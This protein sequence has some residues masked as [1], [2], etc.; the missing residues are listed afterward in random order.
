VGV[1]GIDQSV[2]RRIED[3]YAL[4]ISSADILDLL[5]SLGIKFS[6]A[7]LRK[8]VQLGLLPRSVRVGIKGKNTGSH[9]MYPVTVVRQIIEIKEL[10]SDGLTIEQVQQNVL[11]MRGELEELRRAI[12]KVFV[13][14]EAVV[15]KVESQSLRNSVSVD[16]NHARA[17]ADQLLERLANVE[18]NLARRC[19]IME[20]PAATG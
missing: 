20:V 17:M 6:E 15:D 12:A 3:E 10:L 4:G 11:F 18:T 16:L 1:G 9:G 19:E 7:T 5:A 13:T 14:L 8:W 2:L